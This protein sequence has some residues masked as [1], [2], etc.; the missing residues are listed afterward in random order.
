MHVIYLRAKGFR[1]GT[2]VEAADVHRNSVTRWTKIYM[3]QGVEG[4]RS[5]AC[6]RPVSDLVSY[7]DKIKADFKETPPRDVSEARKRIKQLTGLKRG[8]TQVRKFVKHVLNFRYRKFRPLPGGGLTIEELATKQA[9]FLEETLNPLLSKALR[10]KCDVFFVDAAHP[11]QGFHNGHV[12][13][14]VP[15]FVRTSSGRQRMNILGAMHATTHKLYSIS[16]TDYIKATTVVELIEFLR[17]E[18]PGKSIHLVLDNA[19]YQK[20]ELVVKAARKHRVHLVYLPPYSPNLNLI[21]RFWKYLKKKVLAGVHY[22]T[23]PDF[24]KAIHDFIDEVNEELHDEEIKQLM[25][26]NFQKLAA[27]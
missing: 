13:S 7:A 19:A 1:P 15:I 26:L 23:K 17:Q 18:L 8:L 16:T 12:W 11:V 14:E 6:Y 9:T 22:A 21:E 2:C 24:I 20:C 4:L 5:V 10:N 3:E 27:A 25:T